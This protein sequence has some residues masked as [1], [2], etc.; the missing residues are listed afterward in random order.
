MVRGNPECQQ[1][2]TEV[3]P[4]IGGCT[5]EQWMIT[6]KMMNNKGLLGPEDDSVIE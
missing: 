2:K 3:C 5:T 6:H 1:Q 4:N